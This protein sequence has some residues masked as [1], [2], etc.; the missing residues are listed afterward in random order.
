MSYIHSGGSNSGRSPLMTRSYQPSPANSRHSLSSPKSTLTRNKK[1]AD[2]MSSNS[3][4]ASSVGQQIRTQLPQFLQKLRSNPNQSN[5]KH[6]APSNVNTNIT[7]NPLLDRQRQSSLQSLNDENQQQMPNKNQVMVGSYQRL[8]LD[9]DPNLRRDMNGMNGRH[10]PQSSIGGDTDYGQ[11]D[12]D[13]SDGQT[14]HPSSDGE[15]IDGSFYAQTDLAECM[16]RAAQNAGF[17][18]NEQSFVIEPQTQLM[19]NNNTN[20]KKFRHHQ[21]PHIPNFR[22]TSPY[23]TDS[24]MSTAAP[25]QSRHPPKFR[26]RHGSDRMPNNN[27]IQSP[28]SCSEHSPSYEMIDKDFN[29]HLQQ[30]SIKVPNAMHSSNPCMSSLSSF[31]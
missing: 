27:Q 11:C 4:D 29:N 22:P 17:T 25:M 30:K 16:A 8:E 2:I 21:R 26:R 13:Q 3:M 15:E 14:S 1:V 24:N 31:H 19:S 5:G 12:R 10:S 6:Y 28:S 18:F 20:N 23:S 7:I 9:S